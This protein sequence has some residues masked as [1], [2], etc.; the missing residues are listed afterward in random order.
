MSISCWIDPGTNETS[1]D[2]GAWY[3][4]VPVRWVERPEGLDRLSEVAEAILSD[5]R[6]VI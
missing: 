4:R 6:T 3:S 1:S 2:C 5:A